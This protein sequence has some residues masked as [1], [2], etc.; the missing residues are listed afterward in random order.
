M[1]PGRIIVSA[2]VPIRVNVPN[3]EFGCANGGVGVGVVGACILDKQRRSGR[4][5]DWYGANGSVT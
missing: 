2:N 3:L 5:L 4:I 1:C